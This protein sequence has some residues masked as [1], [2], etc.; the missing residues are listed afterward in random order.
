[1][2]GS[3]MKSGVRTVPCPFPSHAAAPAASLITVLVVIVLIVGV[4]GDAI[5]AAVQ[6]MKRKP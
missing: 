6:W 4:C 2:E 1:M 5:M 3:I